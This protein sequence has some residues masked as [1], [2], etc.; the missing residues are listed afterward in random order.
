MKGSNQTFH[1][2]FCSIKICKILSKYTVQYKTLEGSMTADKVRSC[3][4]D[5]L[6]YIV[7]IYFI[8]KYDNY[9]NIPA[10]LSLEER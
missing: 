6:Y 2:I 10:E 9:I 7:S 3:S 1:L 5:C 4:F 8:I